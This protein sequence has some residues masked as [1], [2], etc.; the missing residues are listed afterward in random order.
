MK[1]EVLKE[2]LKKAI[3]TCEKIT[4]KITTLPALQN[5]LMTA[6]GNFLQLTT[7]NLETTI[8][9]GV[10][11]K[12]IKKGRVAVPATFFANLVNLIISEKLALQEENKNLILV[13]ENQEVQIQGQDPEEFPIVPKI[14]KGE[15]WQITT[16]Q[17]IQ[18]LAPV[19]DV[20]SVSQIRP[21]ISGIYFN[22]RGGRLKLVGTD[23]F[24]LAE[25]V[26]DLKTKNQLE[27][28]FILPQATGRELLNIFSQERGV[29]SI[30]T[31][32]NQAL[33]EFQNEEASYPQVAVLS[34]LIEGSYPN[35][36][37]IIPKASVAKIQLDREGFANQI[38]KAGLFSG[39][40]SE[41]KLTTL[42]D[43]S[44]LRIFSQSHDTGRNEAY[45]NCA[46][47][48]GKEMEIAF[49]YRFLLDGLNCLRSSEAVLELSEGE[50]P[51]VLKP[52]GDDTFLYILM[53]I[54]ST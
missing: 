34:R 2:N 49:N 35:Y 22:L 29:V 18:A 3:N 8:K 10:L 27:S 47:V 15:P 19:V 40:I 44:Q 48:E 33:F 20:P 5:V 42:P 12:V 39:K 51:G 25:K 52:V 21:E 14:E 7:T 43:K 50:G 17:F 28:S 23:S 36:E 9:W 4:R 1:I 53:P 38:K 45:F 31:T 32:P 13:S 54:K 6:E 37:A 30:Y 16:E 41:V 24:R 26:T 46:T 11:A